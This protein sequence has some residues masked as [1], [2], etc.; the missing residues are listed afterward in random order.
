MSIEDVVT[1]EVYKFRVYVLKFKELID[2]L[3]QNEAGKYEASRSL[4]N[5]RLKYKKY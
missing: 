1:N 5:Q 3:Q 2:T 4:K